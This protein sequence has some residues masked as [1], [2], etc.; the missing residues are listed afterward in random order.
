MKKVY[1]LLFFLCLSCIIAYAEESEKDMFLKLDNSLKNREKFEKLKQ[2]EI[3]QLH[4]RASKATNMRSLYRI[5]INLYD[6][7]RSYKYD[8]AWV[9]TNKSEQLAQKLHDIGYVVESRCAKTFCLLS[10]GLYKEAFDEFHSIDVT[11]VSKHYRICYYQLAS[12]L[13]YDIADY[14]HAP[15]YQK[16]YVRQGGIY[17]DSLLKLLPEKSTDWWYAKGMKQMKER[18]YDAST[19]SFKMLLQKP[20]LDTHFK[21]IINSCLGWVAYLQKNKSSSMK[22]LI[23]AAIF[24]NE[25]ATKETTALREVGAL[26]YKQGDIQR[27]IHYVQMALDDANFY[28]ARQRKIEIGNVLPIIQQERFNMVEK[29][30]NIILIATLIAVALLVVL[31]FSFILIRRQMKKLQ[32][33]RLIIEER[34]H[35][36]QQTN[37][38]LQEAN[39]IKDEYIGKSFYI[40]SE[41]IEK[42]EKLY[43]IVDRKIAARQFDD[44]RSL[45]KES[46]L[47]AERKNM[48]ADFDETFLFLFPDFVE[49]FNTLF[50]SGDRKMSLKT[51]SLTT[52]M[53]IFALIRLGISDSE[54]I[55]K[56]LNYSVHTI[57]TYKTRVKNKSIVENENFEAEIMK[58]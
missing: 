33:A 54:R 18:Q 17:V 44:L 46:T 2:E 41:Y 26:L 1:F 32:E 7:Y 27:A 6:A 42:V 40:N 52:E 45:L 9:Y 15:A 11:C 43:K 30:R 13:F 3:S 22:Y 58:I 49:K 23:Q 57:N 51:H 25:S 5:D 24:D 21:A 38:Q 4:V 14:N 29:Q 53:R 50:K 31:F 48:Y 55:A 28:G 39:K 37:D 35:S 34:N 36:L 19:Y 20:N 47:I 12:R 8:S 16:K 56:F 10:A